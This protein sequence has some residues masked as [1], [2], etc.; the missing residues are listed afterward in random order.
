MDDRTKYIAIL[1]GEFNDGFQPLTRAKFWSLY[2]QYDD[3]ITNLI[4]SDEEIIQTLMMRS[5]SVA[6]KLEELKQKGIEVT[7]F[8]DD[9][10]PKKIKSKLGDKCPPLLYFCGD[11]SINQFK[12]VGYVG[13]RTINDKDIAWVEQMINLNMGKGFCIVSGGAKGIDITSSSYT[14]KKNGYVVEY[15]ADGIETKIKDKEVLRYILAG[16]LLLYTATSPF[17]LKSKQKFVG[18]AME[19][20]K[21]IYAHSN[22]TIVVKS[23]YETGGT[24]P[25]AIEA[26]KYKLCI[27]YVW[28][29]KIYKGNQELIERG[30]IAVGDDGSIQEAIIRTSVL[31]TEKTTVKLVTKTRKQS[32]KKIVENQTKENQI[33]GTTN[34]QSLNEPFEQLDLFDISKR[35]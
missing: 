6:F 23:D 15:L 24:W 12:F 19:R 18:N 2:H 5:G 33:H 28:D 9:N 21:F 3:S 34:V 30:G 13:S 29:N 27:V 17:A 22:A 10:Y 31:A 8:F 20:N 32:K 4:T 11:T 26:I 7:S 16:K 1:C 25:G 14:L 35:D